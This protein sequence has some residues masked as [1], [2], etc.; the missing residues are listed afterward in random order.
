MTNIEIMDVVWVAS[1]YML[2]AVPFG[3]VVA[4]LAG[5]GDVRRTGSGNIGATNVLRTAGKTAGAITLMLDMLK[6]ALPV[7]LSVAA[8]GAESTL[9]ACVTLAAF[10]GHC[11]PVYLGFRGGKGVATGLGVFLAWTPWHG[12]GAVLAWLAGAKFWKISSLGGL[13]AFGS[14]PVTL[15]IWPPAPLAPFIALAVSGV[16]FWRHR[17]NIRRLWLGTE[18]RIGATKESGSTTG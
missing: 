3:L 17:A 8:N 15:W 1:S 16:V 10:S 18:P 13:L 5:A 14:L 2:G 9:T 7:L 6:G 11:Y 12:L 4:R